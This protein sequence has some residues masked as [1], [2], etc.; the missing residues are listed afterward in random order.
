MSNNGFTT[1]IALTVRYRQEEVTGL[2]LLNVKIPSEKV[3]Q[4]AGKEKI[5]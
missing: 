3:E 5:N 1:L 4:N 2:I